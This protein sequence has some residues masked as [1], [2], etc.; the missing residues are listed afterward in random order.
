MSKKINF[1]T[2]DGRCIRGCGRKATF[3]VNFGQ[4]YDQQLFGLC[5]YCS[6]NESL[7]W[8]VEKTK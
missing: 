4:K 6:K 7:R 1:E 5:G 3:I 2:I 8:K